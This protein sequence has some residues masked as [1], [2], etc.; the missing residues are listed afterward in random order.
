MATP[1]ERRFLEQKLKAQGFTAGLTNWP[2]RVTYYK[3]DG[4]AL[5]NLPADPEHMQKYLSRGFT[6][7]P[8][9]AVATP[10]PPVAALVAGTAETPQPIVQELVTPR[11][12]HAGGRPRRA[13]RSPSRER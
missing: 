8:P 5:P 4:E 1:T 12:K 7:K 10:A 6:L 2:R 3:P 11:P 9:V 13:R